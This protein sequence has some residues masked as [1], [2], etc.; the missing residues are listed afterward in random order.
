MEFRTLR[1]GLER[2]IATLEL[3]RPQKANAMDLEMWQELPRAL[4]WL[5][6]TPAAHVGVLSGAGKHFTAGIDLSLLAGL[7]NAV[8]DR[9]EA[10][11]REKLRLKILELQACVSSLERCRKPVLAAVHGACL[12]AGVDLVTACDIRYCS[13]D[14]SFSV[15]EVDLGM[16]GDVGTLQRLPRLVGE[17]VA[18]ELAYTGRTVSGDEAQEIRLVNRCYASRDEM[19]KAVHEIAAAIADK[20]PLA[21]RGCKEMITYVRD[22][23]T[24]DAL[25]YVATWN[26]AM[27]LSDDLGEGVGAALERRAPRF[28]D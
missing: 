21:V 28:A 22:H 2:G 23:S 3:H 19:M 16:T 5:D 11:T 14:A 15:K 20:S 26:A 12:G 9:C 10:R 25:N 8:R 1:V 7:G 24:A 4:E 18:R 13:A 27:L 17:G 6:T